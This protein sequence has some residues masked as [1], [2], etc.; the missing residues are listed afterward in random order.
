MFFRESN[1]RKRVEG[2]QES[3]SCSLSFRLL[4]LSNTKRTTM[5]WNGLS[6]A[7]HASVR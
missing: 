2:V 3:L 7:L 6:S 4:S 1:E 5:P